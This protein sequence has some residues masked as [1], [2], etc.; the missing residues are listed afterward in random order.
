MTMLPIHLDA[1]EI[2]GFGLI[3]LECDFSKDASCPHCFP[4]T[5]VQ[6]RLRQKA[7]AMFLDSSRTL[8]LEAADLI[9]ALEDMK[10]QIQALTGKD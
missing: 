10:S 2:E 3:G 7:K 4:D 8:L 1:Q 9:D 6:A 5:S